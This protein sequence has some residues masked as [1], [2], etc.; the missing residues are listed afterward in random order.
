MRTKPSVDLSSAAN[1]VKKAGKG[2]DTCIGILQELQV[3]YGYLHAEVLRYVIDNTRISMR[4]IYG[5]ATF[6]D[7]FRFTP[8]GRHMIRVCHGTACHVN[9][10]ERI[11]QAVE[12]VL[13]IK[14]HETTDDGLFTLESVAC[15]G[16][17]SLAPV[18]MVDN[19]VYGRLTPGEARKIIKT[20][21][22]KDH[23]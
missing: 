12:N 18:M 20:C 11:S 23:S 17:C 9:G 10:A 2:R 3:A 7:Q 1:I 19:T 21:Q 15:L 16:C 4:Q 6:Y 14:N 13:K 22:K 8:V 5:V